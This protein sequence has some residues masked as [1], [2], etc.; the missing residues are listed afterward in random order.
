VESAVWKILRRE[1]KSF[2]RTSFEPYLST[3]MDT[4]LAYISTRVLKGKVKRF[5]SERLSE[6]F[7][8]RELADLHLAINDPAFVCES[9][10][11][12]WWNEEDSKVGWYDSD[13]R[14]LLCPCML[15]LLFD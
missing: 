4:F 8:P 7:T 5:A 12:V 10:E 11:R 1:M 9:E 2:L 14:I 3:T 15:Y 6:H 13:S